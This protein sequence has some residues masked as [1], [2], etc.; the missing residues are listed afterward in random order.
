MQSEEY[1]F[2]YILLRKLA[3]CV[4]LAHLFEKHAVL[5][6]AKSLCH[7]NFRTLPAKTLS[8]AIVGFNDFLIEAM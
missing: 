7:V 6:V 3:K 8:K 2:L 5:E 4:E 1:V